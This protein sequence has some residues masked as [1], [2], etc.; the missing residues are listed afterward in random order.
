MAVDHAPGC[1]LYPVHWL[2]HSV[3]AVNLLLTEADEGPP[4]RLSAAALLNS[5]EYHAELE[6]WATVTLLDV[7]RYASLLGNGRFDE[8][9]SCGAATG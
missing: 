9:C 7:A 6:A 8:M 4:D 3:A 5:L 1:V 2:R